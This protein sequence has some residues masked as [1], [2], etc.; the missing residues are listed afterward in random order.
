[1]HSPA[2]KLRSILD[3]ERSATKRRLAFR[4]Y[5]AGLGNY[6]MS[7]DVG[8]ALAF[9]D[10]RELVPYGCG[11][12]WRSTRPRVES[13]TAR[14]TTSIFDL[15][16]I[17]VAIDLSRLR[18]T[19]RPPGVGCDW[20]ALYES[21]FHN[22]RAED[23][24]G[25]RNFRFFR[26][27]RSNIVT[28]GD[29]R[30]VASDLV[31]DAATLTSYAYFF[32]LDNRTSHE[33]TAVMR[34]VRPLAAFHDL[35]HSFASAIGRYNA[36]HVRRGDFVTSLYTPRACQV[37]CEEIVRNL[38]EVLDRNTPLILCTDADELSFFEPLFR[39]FPNAL[40]LERELLQNTKWRARFD[41]LPFNDDHALSVV[42]QQIASLADT[43]VGT[44]FSS[45]TA[46]IQRTR[47]FGGDPRFLYCYNDWPHYPQVVFKRCEFVATRG[48]P[49][50]W[51]RIRYPVHPRAYSWLRDWP[52]AF[53][54]LRV[55]DAL[56][57][58]ITATMQM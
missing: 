13:G 53:R 57:G 56:P 41:E 58:I 39:T 48:G 37:T 17:P 23:L 38:E 33:L 26:N 44:L 24:R 34:R 49:Y 46:E 31:I 36:V 5:H 50:T 15:F 40:L 42:V 43:F 18:D 45:F 16:E 11:T 8:I 47:G 30:T 1:M 22:F 55:E 52:E 54:G 51:N 21:V 29:Q 12:P 9:L 25:D 6:K 4:M 20:G 32:Y 10:R 19:D 7:M 3:H 14:C 28:L 27:G 35:A 2:A